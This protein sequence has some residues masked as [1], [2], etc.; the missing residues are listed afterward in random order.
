MEKEEQKYLIEKGKL[1]A[2]GAISE[3][4]TIILIGIFLLFIYSTFIRST[5]DTD[6][7]MWTRSGVTLIT[8]YGTG[9]QYLYKDGQLTPRLDRNGKVMI[10][11]VSK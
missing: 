10:T 7:S 4:S 11:D 2:R 8:D 1:F 3:I 5:D 6:K 9:V